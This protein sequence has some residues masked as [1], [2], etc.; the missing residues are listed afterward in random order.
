MMVVINAIEGFPEFTRF[1]IASYLREGARS[2]RELAG[3]LEVRQLQLT[4]V[5]VAEQSRRGGDGGGRCSGRADKGVPAGTLRAAVYAAP[6]GFPTAQTI[7]SPA[8]G[9]CRALVGLYCL[10]DR[11]SMP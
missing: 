11:D 9:G 3:N 4:H 7:S 1:S 8:N 10:D 5:R 6:A 2:R